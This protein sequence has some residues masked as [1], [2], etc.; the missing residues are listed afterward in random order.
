MSGAEHLI[1]VDTIRTRSGCVVRAAAMADLDAIAAVEL[2]AFRDAYGDPVPTAKIQAV[3]AMYADRISLLGPWVRVVD[4]T[5][6]GPVGVLVG[7]PT[8]LEG[9]VIVKLNL[10]YTQAIRRSTTQTGPG[11][12]SSISRSPR[13]AKPARPRWTSSSVRDWPGPMSGKSPSAAGC[14]ASPLGW[15]SSF[16]ASTRLP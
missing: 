15:A 8:S 16:P 13:P 10:A 7:C 2:R 14:P 12:T 11:C 1:S 5:R 6:L 4:D 9:R 3:R